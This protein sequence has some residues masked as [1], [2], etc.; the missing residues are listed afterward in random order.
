[1]RPDL[2]TS[3]RQQQTL[4]VAIHASSLWDGF[5]FRR[6]SDELFRIWDQGGMELHFKMAELAIADAALCDALFLAA[7]AGFPG[8]YTYEV[9]EALGQL[10]AGHLVSTGVFPSDAQWQNALAELA[11]E[12]FRQ[13][14]FT[15]QEIER[16]RQVIAQQ[17][18]LWQASVEEVQTNTASPPV[19]SLPP[20]S[21]PPSKTTT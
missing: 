19:L 7:D 5:V 1:M 16:L 18:P 9:T 8:V 13:G 20:P 15:P 10:I 2:S 11:L 17:L 6:D 3:A 12:F 4:D 21:S 14:P